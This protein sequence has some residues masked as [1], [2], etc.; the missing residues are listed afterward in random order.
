MSTE[1]KV[2]IAAKLIDA[3]AHKESALAEVLEAAS[4]FKNETAE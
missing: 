4:K 2:N 1:E 3:A